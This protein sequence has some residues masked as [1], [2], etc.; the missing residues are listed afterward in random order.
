MNSKNINTILYFYKKMFY[1]LIFILQ[2]NK[3]KI[4]N[5]RLILVQSNIFF[6]LIKKLVN[7]LTTNNK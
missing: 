6:K 2:G 7:N 3:I 1:F 5:I 4:T